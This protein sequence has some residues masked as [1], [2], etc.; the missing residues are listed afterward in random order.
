MRPQ[1][2]IDLCNLL[3]LQPP[4]DVQPN[5]DDAQFSAMLAK[6]DRREPLTPAALNAATWFCVD[7]LDEL[8][9]AQ[10]RSVLKH[11]EQPVTGGQQQ[12]L[13][14]V[15]DAM[16][17]G[18][19]PKC[20]VCKDGDLSFA[21]DT[22]LYTCH[23]YSSAWAKCD[24]ACTGF[25]SLQR[26]PFKPLNGICAFL[27][28]WPAR[29]QYSQGAWLGRESELFD[30]TAKAAQLAQ[31]RANALDVVPAASATSNASGADSPTLDARFQARTVAAA[32][33]QLTDEELASRWR[34]FLCAPVLDAAGECATQAAN[35]VVTNRQWTAPPKVG[36]QGMPPTTRVVK[37]GENDYYHAMLIKVNLERNSN[38]YF[39][40]Q[41]LQSTNRTFHVWTK[42]GRIG[43]DI[44]SSKLAIEF[45]LAAAVAT[46]ESKFLEKSG[47][48]WSARHVFEK[49][50]GL[51]H[52]MD[53][54]A[55]A[56]GAVDSNGGGG[57]GEGGVALGD[58]EDGNDSQVPSRLDPAVQL[59]MRLLFNH[60]NVEVM[61]EAMQ[62]DSRKMP[63]G[64]L[65]Q[66]TI[67]QAF[68]V[69]TLLESALSS[70]TPSVAAIQSQTARFYTLVP[71]VADA[72]KSLPPLDSL[73]AVREKIR[74]VETLRELIVLQSMF[75]TPG[76][77]TL[78]PLDARYAKLQCRLEPVP[79]DSEIHRNVVR[80]AAETHE[81]LKVRCRVSRVFRVSREGEADEFRAAQAELS[82]NARLLW[83]G[84]RLVN[85]VGIL[86]QGLRV[87][88]KSAPKT[89]YMF[90]KGVY[91]ADVFGKSAEYCHA[92][93]APGSATAPGLML[94]NEVLLGDSHTL[95]EGQ[96]V[97]PSEL[98]FLGRHSVHGRGKQAPS[99]APVAVDPA[100]PQLTAA[101]GPLSADYDGGKRELDHSEY[102]VF[103]PSHIKMRYLV[104]LE[105]SGF[106]KAPNSAMM[107]HDSRRL[108]YRRSSIS[109]SEE[110]Y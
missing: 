13:E 53:D 65:T 35:V 56:V 104:L 67:E 87:A 22:N 20:P 95:D 47:N 33:A 91:F 25:Y 18:R 85:F 2:Q 79:V 16:L 73:A 3:E 107:L 12:V 39:Q 5:L 60:R 34:D 105:F 70:P 19:L 52:L 54:S 45:S 21:H 36:A 1:V 48:E 69:L 24:F 58:M 6:L 15:I 89:G 97:E 14:R 102:V 110:N 42:W 81:P 94:L 31:A 64:K 28:G 100:E 17:F 49:K 29:R 62:F 55:D 63:L 8:S 51:M 83:H 27:D 78:S 74:M 61:L 82:H 23:G 50:A 66:A 84:S 77:A 76:T 80:I 108:A 109:S 98:R 71:H 32:A 44:G 92:T 57:G 46:F 30:A 10:L 86:S 37:C 41:L 101:V 26:S 7:A 96:Y 11:N 106:E 88:P 40:L 90:G 9:L 72:A 4:D 99:G 75:A 103:D 93:P 43:T 38:S 59:V 68:S